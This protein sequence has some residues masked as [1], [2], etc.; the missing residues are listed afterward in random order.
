MAPTPASIS[1][2]VCGSGM[3]AMTGVTSDGDVAACTDGSCGSA[4]RGS[5]G[6]LDGGPTTPGMEEG[7]DEK[8]APGDGTFV[9]GSSIGTV[10]SSGGEGSPGARKVGPSSASE[11]GAPGSTG[12]PPVTGSDPVRVIRLTL[13]HTVG[14]RMHSAPSQ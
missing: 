11:I 9:D 8:G 4:P 6:P 13:R 12:D 5:A 3:G 1:A 14:T 7:A 10:V 2:H